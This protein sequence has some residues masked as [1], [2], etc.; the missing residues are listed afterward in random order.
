MP[1]YLKFN[2]NWEYTSEPSEAFFDGSEEVPVQKVRLPHTGTELP[3]NYTDENSFQYEAGYRTKLKLPPLG[4]R[5]LFFRCLGAAQQARLQWNGNTLCL[6]KCGYT[7]FGTELTQYAAEGS[8]LLTILVDSR[9]SLNQP[10]F[11]NQIDYLCYQGLYRGCE[12]IL[13]GSSFIADCFLHSKGKTLSADVWICGSRGHALRVTVRDR[14]GNSVHSRHFALEDEA[15]SIP[16]PSGMMVSQEECSPYSFSLDCSDVEK[17]SVDSPIL[18]D[19]ILELFNQSGRIIDSRTCR[20]GFRDAV[21]NRDGFFLNNTPLKLVGLDRHQ[22]FPYVGYAL[23]DSAQIIDA[24]ILKY[25]LGLNIVRTSH[26][27]QSQAFLDRCDEIGLLVFT[28]IPGWQYIGGDSW[29]EQAVQNVGDMICQ[30][31][32]HPSIVLWGVR[33]NESRDDDRLYDATNALAHRMDPY[34]QTGGV[35][36]IR[37]SSLLEDVYTYNDFHHNGSNEGLA[38]KRDVVDTDCPYL[39]TE[40]NGHMFPTKSFDDEKHRTEHALRHARVLDKMF[41]SKGISGCIGWCAFDYNTHRDF[42]SGDRI[43]YHGVMDMS[44]IPKPAAAV[45]ASQNDAAPVLE[46][47]SNMDRGDWPEGTAHVIWAFTNADSLKLYRGGRLIREFFPDKKD[48]PNLPHPPIKIDDFIGN[49]LAEDEKIE[50]K[51]AERIKAILAKY[52]FHNDDRSVD[53]IRKQTAVKLLDGVNY[54]ELARLKS[55]YYDSWGDG[56]EDYR[57][58]AVK[59]GEIVAVVR[60][61]AADSFALKAKPFRSELVENGMWDADLVRITAVDQNGSRLWYA[62]DV[63]QLETE[64]AIELIGDPFVPLIGGAAGIWVRTVGRTGTGTLRMKCRNR[65]YAVSYT[66]SD[67]R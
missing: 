56:S 64:G 9:E 33:I 46:L 55:K 10:P 17:W 16:F 58:E 37:H 66:V 48:F 5:R 44:R 54:E 40:Y 3:W 63:V 26:Y 28:E 32:N 41:G 12:L 29:K 31:R 47:S 4:E 24:D 25:E 20:F 49:S 2:D 22:S 42:G 45:Y 23:P 27:P 19:V 51:S 14:D 62:S 8:N 11:G 43:C 50:Q 15:E 59:N 65:S 13:T 7:A 60:K 53:F 18:Y 1:K 52:S 57:F 67:G 30:Y 38:E 36:C 35:R 39:I 21:F 61:G 34:R 6:H